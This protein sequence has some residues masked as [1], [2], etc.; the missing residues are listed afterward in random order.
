MMWGVYELSK[1]YILNMRPNQLLKKK[2]R[3]EGLYT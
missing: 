2:K 1:K 3:I